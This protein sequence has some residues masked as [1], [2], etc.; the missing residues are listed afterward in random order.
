MTKLKQAQIDFAN[1]YGNPIT[2]TFD[3]QIVELEMM[4]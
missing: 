3:L 1:L 4:T 2:S